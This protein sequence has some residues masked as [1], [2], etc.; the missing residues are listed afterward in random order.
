M[1]FFATEPTEFKESKNRSF[2]VLNVM[3]VVG[4]DNERRMAGK[5]MQVKWGSFQQD[6]IELLAFL[7]FVSHPRDFIH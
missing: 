4:E 5:A 3:G 7:T 6:D 1:S 2:K